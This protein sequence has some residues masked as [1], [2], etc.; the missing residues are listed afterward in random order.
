[1]ENSFDFCQCLA[2]HNPRVAG[3]FANVWQIRPIFAKH[4]QNESSRREMRRVLTSY[5]LLLPSYFATAPRRRALAR[6]RGRRY[7]SSFA[8]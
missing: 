3:G 6:G 4:W 8:P 5:F 7:L 1:L 2:K